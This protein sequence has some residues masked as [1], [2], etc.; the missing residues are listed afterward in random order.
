MLH[1][2]PSYWRDMVIRRNPR[3]DGPEW[4][5]AAALTQSLDVH[6]PRVSAGKSPRITLHYLSDE[7]WERYREKVKGWDV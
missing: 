3:L 1:P 4:K 5:D 2:I 6:C 7:H